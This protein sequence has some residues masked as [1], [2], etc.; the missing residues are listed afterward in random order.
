MAK[1][2]DIWVYQKNENVVFDH[3]F[4]CYVGSDG[5]FS[6]ILG[7]H[8]VEF[9]AFLKR[10]AD[11]KE[12]E[13][14][15]DRQGRM[16]ATSGNKSKLELALKRY[17]EETLQGEQDVRLFIY[18]NAGCQG[19]IGLTANRQPMP[20]READRDELHHFGG[21]GRSY[22]GASSVRADPSLA[23]V[24]VTQTKTRS[25]GVAYRCE[26]VSS[27]DAD[28]SGDADV[29]AG[30]SSCHISSGDWERLNKHMRPLTDAAA[31]EVRRVYEA[32]MMALYDLDALSLAVPD[33]ATL[34]GG[35]A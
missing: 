16:R 7:N 10:A 11:L 29:L 24:R 4:P 2:A 18:F 23:I 9:K 28:T 30:W 32:T 27:G 1:L 5:V 33:K 21:E 3:K 19:T 15:I 34:F 12:V 14:T 25:G 26:R 8:D 22:F 20:A 31:A 17:A 6:A 35:D 13:T